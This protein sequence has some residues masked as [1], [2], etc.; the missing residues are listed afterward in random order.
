M[1]TKCNEENQNILFNQRMFLWAGISGIAI[2]IGY[3]VITILFVLS[4]SPLPKDAFSWLTYLNGKSSLWWFIIWFSIITDILYILVAYGLYEFLKKSHKGIMLISLML[5]ILFVF[6][7]LAITWSKYPALLE[8]VSR[9]QA[10]ENN[11]LRTIYLAAIETLSVEFQTPI[12]AF[13]CI[14]IP[15]IA[16]ILAS[17][18][19]IK[20]RVGSIAISVI[21]LIS[22]TCNA[23]SA[24]GRYIFEPLESIVVLGSF[25]SLFWFLGIGVTLIKKRKIIPN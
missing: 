25:L 13:Y 2:A 7:E 12:T 5:F 4:G 10:T 20:E 15:S 18:V 3:V 22:G 11:E 8:I 14:F 23:I 21:G 1:K 16:V 24:L 17:Y 6:L 19:M 9:Y